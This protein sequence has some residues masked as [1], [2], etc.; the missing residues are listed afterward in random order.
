MQQDDGSRKQ[1]REATGFSARR[2]EKVQEIKNSA[3]ECRQAIW[4]T[5]LIDLVESIHNM[6][7]P[8]NRG[9]SSGTGAQFRRLLTR[10]E[11][12]TLLGMILCIFSLFL[13]WPVPFS[14]RALPAAIVINLTRTGAAM[15]EVRWPV[16][17]GAILSGLLLA[18]TPSAAARIPLAFVQAL[19]GLIC[20]IIALMHFGIQPG[21]LIELFGGALLTFGAV[22]RLGQPPQGAKR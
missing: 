10:A 9:W 12:V 1:N 3:P 6:A 5:I 7:V 13:P 19:C 18:F 21:P 17:I 15:D 4:Y 8:P 2:I 14:G 11:A 20:F 22:D 16:T